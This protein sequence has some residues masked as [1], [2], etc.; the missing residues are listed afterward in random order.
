MEETPIER[1]LTNKERNLI[2]ERDFLPHM[3]ALLNFAYRLSYD[4][5]LAEDLVQETFLKACQSI[6]SFQVGTNAKAW[7]FTILRNIFINNYRKKN[8][9]T[10]LS[11]YCSV[12]LL[13]C[14][15]RY[16]QIAVRI[17]W[18]FGYYLAP[19]RFGATFCKNYTL[20]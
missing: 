7:L 8:Q 3:N 10:H 17:L 1:V 14:L 6:A 4:E 18:L 9:A 19:K 2:V 15:D 20:S 11:G 13:N 16:W 5:T 12:L